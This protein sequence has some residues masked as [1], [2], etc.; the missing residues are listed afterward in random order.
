[1]SKGSYPLAQGIK[2]RTLSD[3]KSISESFVNTDEYRYVFKWTA[4]MNIAFVAIYGLDPPFVT[5]TFYSGMWEIL[6]LETQNPIVILSLIL[7]LDLIVA[8]PFITALRHGYF[9]DDLKTEEPYFHLRMNDFACRVPFRLSLYLY[10]LG[11]ATPIISRHMNETHPQAVELA[12][13]ISLFLGYYFGLFIMATMIFGIGF[14]YLTFFGWFRDA[15]DQGEIPQ[16]TVITAI[17]RR[18]Q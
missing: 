18:F 15:H 17:N 8:I 4:I 9:T 13:N 10:L 1:M 6:P 14:T 12:S 7:P 2:D 3:I 5:S 16:Y 11:I